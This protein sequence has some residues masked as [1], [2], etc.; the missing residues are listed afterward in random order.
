[1][2]DTPLFCGT[3]LA[4]RIEAAQAQLIVAATEAAGRRGGAGLVTPVAGGFACFADDGSPMNK[5]VG[6]G[7]GGVPD[8]AVMDEMERMLFD[9]AATVQVELSNLADPAVAALLTDRGYQL[10]GFENVLGRSL[11]SGAQP[12]P[13]PSAG[14]EVQRSTD[15]DAWVEVVVDG[16]AH[17]DGEGVPS[18]EDFPRDIIAR[19]ERDMAA[20]GLMAYAALCDGVIA[21]GGGLCSTDGVAQLSGAATAPAFRRRGVQAALLSARLRDAATAGCDIAVVTTAPG[22]TSQRNVQRN[23]FHLLYTRAV[24]TKSAAL[25]R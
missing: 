1:M 13:Q 7:F 9:C 3:S 16:F 8:G 15:I 2:T 17:P 18:H 10:L 22:S 20:A 6:L 14:V 25:G 12:Q 19:V 24:L 4:R 11:H 23:G 5:V 21:G